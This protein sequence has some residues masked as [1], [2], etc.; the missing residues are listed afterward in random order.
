MNEIERAIEYFE[1]L[2]ARLGNG[3][4]DNRICVTALDAERE[5]RC[6]VLTPSAAAELAMRE[7]DA[8]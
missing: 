1:G 8:E 7:S 5:G 2:I 4:D 3:E 6:F